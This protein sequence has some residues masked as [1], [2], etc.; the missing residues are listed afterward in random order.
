V[1]PVRV[2][3]GAFGPARPTRDLYLSP[4]HAV[5]VEDVLIP[6]RCLVNGDTVVQCPV[7]EITYYH[8]ELACHDIVL[9]EG[10]TVE[11]Y[12]DVTAQVARW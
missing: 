8:V 3:A 1:W 11:S 4:D 6:I 9:A 5:F 10:L 12:L 2:A 7:D